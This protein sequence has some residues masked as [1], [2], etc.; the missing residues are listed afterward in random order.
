MAFVKRN[1]R[2]YDTLESGAVW[3]ANLDSEPVKVNSEYWCRLKEILGEK[4][5]NSIDWGRD[6]KVH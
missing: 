1:N 4:R 3:V 6:E 5:Y 2:I